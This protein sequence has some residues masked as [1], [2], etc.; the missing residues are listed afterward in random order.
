[1]EDTAEFYCVNENGTVCSDR[2][3][4]VTKCRLKWCHMT[5]DK[6]RKMKN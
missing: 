3:G 4:G 6:A 1:M 2:N 5:Y